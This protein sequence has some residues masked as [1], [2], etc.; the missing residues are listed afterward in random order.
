VSVQTFTKTQEIVT[1]AAIAVRTMARGMAQPQQNRRLRHLLL[2]LFAA[3]AVLALA[4]LIWSFVPLSGPSLPADTT[5]LN[6]V[7]QQTTGISGESVDIDRL[8]SWH[9]FGK[10][11]TGS[12]ATVP[13]LDSEQVQS[14]IDRDG[15]EEGARKTQLNLILRGVLA[16]SDE[17]L[18]M[19][20][21]EHNS[22]QQ[23]YAVGDK[24]PVTG[25]VSLAKVMA[26]RVVL[27]NGGT[28]ELLALFSRDGL[29][30]QLASESPGQSS[31]PARATGKKD[32]SRNR[33]TSTNAAS[34]SYRQRLYQNPGSLAQLVSVSPVR[35]SGELRG[36]R[37]APGSDRAQFDQLDL[38][39]GDLITS[40]NGI[41]LNDPANAM[42]LYQMLRS[43]KEAVFELERGG[44]LLT[45][46]LRLD[47]TASNQ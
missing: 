4:R 43:A 14:E 39:P 26:T 12:A 10:E 2:F 41:L 11:G 20:I 15:I 17:G 30:K 21:I 47:D 34:Q 40:V 7:T 25:Q 32:Q 33:S 42:G 5:I 45:V 1:R 24:L 28:Y 29:I 37:I 19:A 31:G 9:L 38:M 6:P 27:D 44:E 16:S 8:V 36:Y 46:V 3:W 23:I 13:L 35:E 18:G 22:K